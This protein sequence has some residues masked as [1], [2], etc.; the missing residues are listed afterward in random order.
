MGQANSNGIPSEHKVN[1][2]EELTF[3]SIIIAAKVLN[4]LG[5]LCLVLEVKAMRLCHP[6]DGSTSP[7]YKLLGFKPP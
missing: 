7:K 6:Q 4:V 1:T 3:L 5:C 2:D